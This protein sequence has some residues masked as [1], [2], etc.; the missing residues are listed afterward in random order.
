MLV[1]SNCVYIATEKFKALE[2]VKSIWKNSTDHILKWVVRGPSISLLF[3][4]LDIVQNIEIIPSLLSFL[5]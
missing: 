1:K 3:Q 5:E 2:I 4:I